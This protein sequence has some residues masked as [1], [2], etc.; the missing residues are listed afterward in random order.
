MQQSPGLVASRFSAGRVAEL[1]FAELT[2]RD[3]AVAGT[4]R[5][6][7]FSWSRRRIWSRRLVASRCS[8]ALVCSGS[9]RP[10]LVRRRTDA[11]RFRGR[12]DLVRRR[13]GL[14]AGLFRPEKKYMPGNPVSSYFT[15]KIYLERWL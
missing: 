2:R 7:I 1:F 14:V 6:A 13:T 11:S 12:L 4:G 8:P 15:R 10:D 9:R 3:A 5:V